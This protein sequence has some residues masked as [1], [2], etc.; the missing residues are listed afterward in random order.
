MSKVCALKFGNSQEFPIGF[1]EITVSGT[2]PSIAV[3]N[4]TIYTCSSTLTSLTLTNILNK[5][6]SIIFTSGLT[7]TTL[8]I[9][10]DLHMPDEFV[11][12]EA[13]RRY[14]INVSDGYALVSS[15]AVNT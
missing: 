2:T 4:N 13:N 12:P 1:T 10:N 8:T 5:D 7:P 9:P 15:W 3:N 6:F 14:E 11:S